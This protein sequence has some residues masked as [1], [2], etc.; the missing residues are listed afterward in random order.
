MTTDR[1]KRLFDISTRHSIY[2]E[3]V[4][5]NLFLEFEKF[6]AELSKQIQILLGRLKI[7]KLGDLTKAQLNVLL[8]KLKQ[9]QASVFDPFR[10]ALVSFLERFS[11]I[12]L[13]MYRRQYATLLNGPKIETDQAAI[14][15]LLGVLGG[16]SV[17]S[18]MGPKAITGDDAR[19]WANLRTTAMPANG[20]QMLGFVKG[21]VSSVSNQ[22][23]RIV[24]QAWANKLS[25]ED[26]LQLLTGTPGSNIG[27]IA[28]GSS[29]Q[30]K[31]IFSQGRSV[32]DTIVQF[33]SSTVG[34]AVGSGFFNR[35]VWNSILDNATTHVC[36]FRNGTVYEY[37]EG[38]LPPAHI[39]CRSQA[40]PLFDTGGVPRPGRYGSW[41]ASQP[42]AVTRDMAGG[43]SVFTSKPLSLTRYQSK[44]SLILTP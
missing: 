44:L 31:R 8:V 17:K 26:L 5:L 27:G 42:E 14:A 40:T 33:V 12:E 13:Q 28:P 39:G 21:F 25:V 32:I 18:L 35:Y 2:V 6:V 30:M 7:R 23:D 10:D 16:K 9:S 4:K 3:G 34:G 20:I 15:V 19:M 24:R 1:N 36:E 41:L 37:G 38:P 43:E 22:I 29:S 11:A